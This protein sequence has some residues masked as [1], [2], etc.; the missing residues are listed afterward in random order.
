MFIVLSGVNGNVECI[1]KLHDIHAVLMD[2][3]KIREFAKH[4]IYEMNAYQS[5]VY[6]FSKKGAK[7][8]KEFSLGFSI[9]WECNV[10]TG[11]VLNHHAEKLH[12]DTFVFLM[13]CNEDGIKIITDLV[14]Q[15]DEAKELTTNP[16]FSPS[17]DFFEILDR[18]EDIVN[19][20]IATVDIAKKM[21]SS[22]KTRDSVVDTPSFGTLKPRSSKPNVTFEERVRVVLIPKSRAAEAKNLY[23]SSTDF[24]RFQREKTEELD[25]HIHVKNVSRAEAGIALYHDGNEDV[26]NNTMENGYCSMDIDSIIRPQPSGQHVDSI[27]LSGGINTFAAPHLKSMLDDDIENESI[28]SSSSSVSAPRFDRLSMDD[29]IDRESM[30]KHQLDKDAQWQQFHISKIKEYSEKKDPVD[31]KKVSIPPRGFVLKR[32]LPPPKDIHPTVVYVSL[33]RCQHLTP[34]IFWPIVPTNSYVRIIVDGE[35]QTSEVV[36][37]KRN[38]KYNSAEVYTFALDYENTVNNYIDFEVYDESV[39]G[40]DALLGCARVAFSALRFQSTP[41]PPQKVTLPLSYTREALENVGS[42]R[43]FF[44]EEMGEELQRLEA[45]YCKPVP[46]EKRKT[47]CITALIAVVDSNLCQSFEMLRNQD[48]EMEER[49]GRGVPWIESDLARRTISS[50]SVLHELAW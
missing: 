5:L 8:D 15:Q 16:N 36:R 17:F 7:T 10:I 39:T 38:P 40:D 31:K 50:D 24:K 42:G 32:Y 13:Y 22:V 3:Y 30:E 47:S 23:F 41:R 44:P 27:R 29:E 12:V 21:V 34:S 45:T 14:L 49:V 43:G 2:Y 28:S 11:I 35:H 6:I 19:I 1:R 33:L 20:N 25:F 46:L 37:R 18:K 26:S 9:E 4:H 48:A